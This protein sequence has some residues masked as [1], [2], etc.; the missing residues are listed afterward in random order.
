[1]MLLKNQIKTLPKN[2]DNP[3]CIMVI[4]NINLS[5]NT[6][7]IFSFKPYVY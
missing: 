4:N 2:N 3:F 5:V 7:F 6:T 1:M